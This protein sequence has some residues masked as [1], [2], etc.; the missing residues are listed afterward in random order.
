M[1]NSSM[2]YALLALLFMAPLSH[3]AE[4][5]SAEKLR[6][7]VTAPGFNRPQ[8]FPGIGEFTWPGNMQRLP[9]GDLLMVHSFG[10]Y[11]SSFALPRRIEPKTRKR[12]LAQGWPL[13]F[14]APTGG[15]S[16]IVRSKD[17]GRTWNR[18]R[19]LIDLPLDD[20]ACGLLR[21]PD[22]TLICTVSVQ[23]SWYGFTKAPAGFENDI[24]GLNTQQ[25][26]LRSIDDGKSWSDPIW[27]KSPGSFYERSHVQPILLQNGSVL[28]STYFSHQDSSSQLY[29]AIHRSDDSGKS[30]RLI[31]TI[32]RKGDTTDV[33]SASAANIDEPAIALLPDGQ[34]FLIT[35]PD[36]GYFFSSDQGETWKYAGRLVTHGKF[37]APRL[38]VLKDGTVVCVC[39]Y[40]NLRVFLGRNNGTDWSEPIP[41]DTSSYGYPGGVLLDDESMQ[42]SYCSSGRSPNSLYVLRFRVNA[43]RDGIDLLPISEP[44]E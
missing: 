1:Q 16:M 21:C 25:C 27:I 19:T 10:Y 44:N 30:W 37:K 26:I 17:G 12:W 24:D 7:T 31:S 9:N 11:H 42:V 41:L 8:R 39:T 40:S 29:G 15:R 13:Q 33:A 4:K 32:S 5:S 18:P 28:W 34:L 6:V 35:R 20:G 14:E 36:G 2:T 38:F 22:G 23:A 3:A 43:E